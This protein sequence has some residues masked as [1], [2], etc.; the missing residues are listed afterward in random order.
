MMKPAVRLS[1]TWTRGD[2]II[3]LALLGVTAAV[4][5][6]VRLHEFIT[7]DDPNYITE[8]LRVQGGLTPANLLWAF[9]TT[10]ESNWHPLTWLSH[11]LDCQWFGLNAGAHHLVNVFFHICN[12]L[13][14]F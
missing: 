7:Y 4:F 14:L 3:C 13:L 1:S 10:S 12:S 9:R 11:M 8:N 2:S 5:W 6:Q